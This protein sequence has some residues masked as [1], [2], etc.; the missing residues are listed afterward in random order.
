MHQENRVI[1]ETVIRYYEENES[2]FKSVEAAARHIVAR[3]LELATHRTIVDWIRV[4][5]KQRSAGTP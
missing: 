3:K 5:R 2:S 1:R 4:Y